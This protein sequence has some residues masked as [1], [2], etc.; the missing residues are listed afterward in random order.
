MLTPSNNQFLK[1]IAFYLPQFHPIPENNI[2]WGK[3]FTEWTNVSRA[4]PLFSGHYQPHI[5]TDLG[6]YDLR[7]SESREAQAS[8]AR[9]H[10]ITGFCYYHYWFH[11]RRLLELPFNEVLQSG[12]PDFPFCLC[13]ANESWARTWDGL[14]SQYLLEQHYSPEDDLAHIRWLSK[15]FHDK[16]YI[17]Y[18]GKPVFLIY[19]AKSL[20]NPLRT[21]S[22]WR[23]EARKL[24]VGDIFLCR[25]ESFPNEHDDPT[26]LGFDAAVEFQPDWSQLRQPQR[27]SF[28]W[29]VVTALRL[30]SQAYQ[31]SK[32]YDYKWV[33]EDMLHKPEPSYQLF[34]C[35]TPSWDNAA[36]KTVDAVIFKNSTPALYENWLQTVVSKLRQGSPQEKLLFINAWNEWGEGNHLEPDLRFGRAYLEATRRVMIGQ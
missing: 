17:R 11:G 19:R 36:R 12:K 16:R 35:V 20:P 7:L 8:L 33:I 1:L 30:S 15:A 4:R 29:R 18:E 5:P 34:R 28:F 31:H 25:V 10:G 32:V 6:F 24:G 2:W 23:E 27:R 3:G 13:W 14:S 9:D 22:L 26:K 21:T